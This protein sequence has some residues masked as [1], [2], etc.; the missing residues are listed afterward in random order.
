MGAYQFIKRTV[1]FLRKKEIIP[2]VQTVFS[3]KLIEGKTVLITGGSGGIGF[4]IA[5]ALCLCARG[6][7]EYCVVWN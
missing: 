5:K 2:I 7:G 6:G 4:A 1:K 3:E